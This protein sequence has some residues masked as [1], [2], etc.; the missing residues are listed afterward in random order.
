[1]NAFLSNVVIPVIYNETRKDF[2]PLVDGYHYIGGFNYFMG[3][4]ITHQRADMKLA[5]GDQDMDG[6]YIELRQQNY[7]GRTNTK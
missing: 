2:D 7:E 6:L 4:R 5:T 3:M 1:M